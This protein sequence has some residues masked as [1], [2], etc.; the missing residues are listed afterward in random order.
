[1]NILFYTILFIIGI[2]IGKY[3]DIEAKEIPKRLDLKKTQYNKNSNE[4]FISQLTYIIIGGMSSVILANTLRI[5][6]NSLD[7]S[8]IVIYIFAMLYVSTLVLIGGIDKNYSKI[9]KKILAFGIVSSIVYMIYIFTIDSSSAY[10]NILY[11]T[12]Y[13]VLLIIDS[14]LLRRFAKDSY[15]L[16]LL[17]LLGI[18]LVYSNF[19]IL[20]YTLIMTLIAILVYIIILESQKKKNGNKKFKINE[21]PVGFFVTT[22]N[23]IILFMIRIFENYLI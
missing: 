16:N 23:I 18:I 8:S 4:K 1:M 10:L 11:L 9:D 21:I 19:Q 6:I 22:S 15:I 5:N 2:V 17:M 12:I 14:F 20:I 7:I 13:M 3:W